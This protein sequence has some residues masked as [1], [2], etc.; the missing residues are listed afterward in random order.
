MLHERL[1]KARL[2]AGFRTASSAIE[3][4]GWRDSTY[5]AH[6]NGQNRFTIDDAKKYAEAYRV[7]LPWLLAEETDVQK[8]QGETTTIHKHDCVEHIRAISILL[9]EDK[10]N[11]D[12]IRK[13]YACTQS[14][15]AKLNI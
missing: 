8:P 7:N 15:K 13:L 9:M 14:L 4:F 10:E 6:E 2:K 5:R 11:T 3:E 1:K 12:L